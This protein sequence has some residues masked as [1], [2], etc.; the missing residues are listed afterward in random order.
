MDGTRTKNVIHKLK[1]YAASAVQRN[2]FSFCLSHWCGT[3]AQWL[4]AA[5]IA[6]NIIRNIKENYNL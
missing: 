3:F 5:R 1:V 6:F 4:Y 2:P